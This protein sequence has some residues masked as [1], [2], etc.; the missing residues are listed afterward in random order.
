MS[1]VGKALVNIEY[2]VP[3][4]YGNLAAWALTEMFAAGGT[5]VAISVTPGDNG[6][7]R[8]S[9]DGDVWYDKSNHENRTP[10]IHDMKDLK[11]RMINLLKSLG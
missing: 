8:I 5:D 1:E 9:V 4:G 10:E 2:C 7:F 11:I 6:I 3:C